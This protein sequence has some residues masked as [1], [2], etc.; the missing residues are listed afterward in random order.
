MIANGGGKKPTSNDSKTSS[1]TISDTTRRVNKSS[2][3]STKVKQNNNFSTV[4]KMTS[5]ST[6]KVDKKSSIK[7]T[8]RTKVK[9]KKISVKSSASKYLG[10][11]IKLKKNSK[12]YSNINNSINKS[13]GYDSYYSYKTLRNIVGCGVKYKSRDILFLEVGEDS[14]QIYD[15][16]KTEN[17]SYDEAQSRLSSIIKDGGKIQAVASRRDSISSG[18]EGFYN[19][20]DVKV[21]RK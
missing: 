5:R 11:K 14:Y 20:D 3:N 6:S 13:N 2:S 4:G 8:K 7:H 16:D 9:S 18:I 19:Y 1:S 17:V 12:I 10:A 15:N 21:L